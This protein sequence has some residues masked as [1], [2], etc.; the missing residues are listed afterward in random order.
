MRETWHVEG[1]GNP[2]GNAMTL[3]ILRKPRVL[4]C[5]GMGGTW[6]DEA[7]KRGDFPA[8]V[9]LGARAVGWRRADVD[10]WMESLER[11]LL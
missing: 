11:R 1:R 7:V 3:E 6:L 8:P 9:K 2:I 4:A 5:I 10:T